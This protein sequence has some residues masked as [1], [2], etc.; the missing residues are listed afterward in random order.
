MRWYGFGPVMTTSGQVLD[1]P[2][3]ARFVTGNL[4]YPP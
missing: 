4:L 1:R 2:L 3:I